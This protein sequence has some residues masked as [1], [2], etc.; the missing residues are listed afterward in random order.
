M[1]K[2]GAFTSFVASVLLLASF[3]AAQEKPTRFTI[4]GVVSG[5]DEFTVTRSA[6]GTSVS[7]HTNF[8]QGPV[9]LDYTYKLAVAPDCTLQKYDLE[10]RLQGQVHTISAARDGDQIK[11]HV[12]TGAGEP[13]DKSVPFSP[14]VFVLDNSITGDFQVMADCVDKLQSADVML[15]VPQRMAALAGKLTAASE[16]TGT[17]NGKPVRARKYSL[18]VATIG[19]DLWF[20]AATH[21]LLRIANA[22][23]NFFVTREGFALNEKSAPQ[24]APVNWIEREVKFPSAEFQFPATLCLPREFKSKAP[25]VVLVHGSGP[26]DRDEAVGP[27]KPF[28][29]IAHA[30]AAAGIATLRY[31]KRTFAFSLQIKA[32]T[33]TLDQEVTDDAVAALAFAATQP[34][35]DAGRL[36]VLGH[37]LGGTMA[38]YIAQKYPKLHGMVLMAAGARPIDQISAEQVRFQLKHEGKSG[39]EIEEAM[40]KHEAGFAAVRKAPAT[41]MFN[42]ISAGYMRDW[43]ARD[44]AKLLRESTVPALVLQGGSDLQVSVADYNLLKAA[45]AGKP[46]SE[47]HL[48]PGMTHMFAPAPPNQTF[49]DITKPAHVD[50]QVT[51]A[52]AEWIKKLN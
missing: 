8:S 7:G 19:V 23:Q 5:A 6:A 29:D 45:I 10:L 13:Q 41:E 37:S 26:H 50:P 24:A 40:K 4:S 48:F 38:P 42:G 30:L 9:A 16:D 35:V 14:V 31:D 44:P 46:N 1:A 18:S 36:F 20:D 51:T 22:G 11:M 33:L 43:L 15:L 2:A 27:N 28:A 12:V 25:L 39:A 3:A 17:L 21:E 49:D 47:A 32:P 34:E 52:I